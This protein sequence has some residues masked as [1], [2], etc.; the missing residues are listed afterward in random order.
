MVR[1]TKTSDAGGRMDVSGE[2]LIKLAERQIRQGLAPPSE[3]YRIE[4]RHR[5]DWLNFPDWGRPVDPEIYAGCCH[6]G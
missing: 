2:A 3:I 1:L 5:M 4:Y 6:E